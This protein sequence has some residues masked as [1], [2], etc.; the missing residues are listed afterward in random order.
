[1]VLVLGRQ[2]AFFFYSHNYLAMSW[3]HDNFHKFV[4]KIR[5]YS[6][7]RPAVEYLMLSDEPELAEMG[8]MESACVATLNLPD[9]DL[10]ADEVIIKDYSENQGIYDCMLKAGHIGP[11]SRY[12]KSGFITAPVCKLLL[13]QKS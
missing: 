12:V 10:E 9:E 13:T 3:I 2:Q 6:N 7:G 5:H 11:A 4:P 8:Y 1:M